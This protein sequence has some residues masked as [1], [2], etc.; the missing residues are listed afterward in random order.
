MKLKLLFLLY[1]C[2]PIF[3]FSQVG[4]GTTNPD[5]S[6]VLDIQSSSGGLLIPRMTAAE[7][8]AIVSP[9]QGLMIYQTDNIQGFYYYDGLV[10]NYLS[11]ATVSAWSLVGNTATDPNVNFIGTLDDNPLV[12]RTNNT[13]NM[14]I[15][16][17]G[18]IGIGTTLNT[19]RLFVNIEDTD[20]TTNYGI[21]NEQA[22]A[23]NDTKY[24]I[25][26]RISDDGTGA[27]YGLFNITRQNVAS[28]EPA[29]G[30]YNY[31][32]SYGPGNAYSLFNYHFAIGTGRSY[33]ISNTLNLTNEN[34]GDV[35][36][37]YHF[38]NASYSNNSATL[39]GAY[40]DIDF[41]SGTRYGT[42]R[43]MSSSSA[44]NGDIYAAYNR[45]HGDG[46]GIM[47]GGFNELSGNGF[48]PKYGLF[49]EFTNGESDKTGVYNDVQNANNGIIYG[50][51]NNFV[52]NSSGTPKYGLYNNFSGNMGTN[53]GVYSNMSQP[54]SSTRSVFGVYSNIQDVGSGTHYGGFFNV[55]GDGHYGVYSI[56]TSAAGYAGYFDGRVRTTGRLEV[57]NDVIPVTDDTY[58]IGSLANRWNTVY[59]TNGTIQTSDIRLKKHVETLNYGLNEVLALTPISYYWKDNV[60]AN[61][62][63]IG[64]SAQNVQEHIK[65]V[66]QED[67]S[68]SVLGVNYG[69]LV[70]VLVKAIQEQQSQIDTLK[71][72]IKSLKKELSS[73]QFRN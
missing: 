64:L 67:K 61:K 40:Y 53:Y 29:Y 30:T 1:V 17:N 65:E 26:N 46:A 21:F 36:L 38:L 14:R 42:Y 27:R 66:V 11:T 18:N 33:G 44:Y 39:Y 5:P 63:K 55:P 70:P 10:W 32:T 9:A 6:S 35:Y 22:G 13:E 28:T 48:G 57:D 41:N 52:N 62:R 71:E 43:T 59:A 8:T 25:Y 12:F 4:I 31:L 20:T 15:N 69:E 34:S 60:F 2:I 16:T 50:T 47:Y 37:N 68:S 24:G 19:A 58:N 72:E 56:N 54:A 73:K 45:I 3:C 23:G 51:Y 49:N 7:K